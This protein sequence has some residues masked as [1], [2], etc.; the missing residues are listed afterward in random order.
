MKAN[1]LLRRI[2]ELSPDDNTDIDILVFD[3]ESGLFD[4]LDIVDVVR[5]ADCSGINA[6]GINVRLSHR[7]D[8]NHEKGTN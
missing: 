5:N 8:V 2:Q 3:W 6:I 4:F 7:L 1:E